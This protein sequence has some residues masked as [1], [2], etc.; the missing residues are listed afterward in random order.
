MLCDVTNR[1][2]VEREL[3]RIKPDV[4][5]HLAAMTSVDW[6][7]Q[8]YEQAC[9]V[10]VYG[11]NIVCEVA[12]NT[13]GE[14]KVA[15]IS[16]DMV[17]DGKDG[18]YDEDAPPNPINAYGMTKFGAE[19]IAQLYNAKIIRISRC[20]HS[21]SPDILEYLEKVKNGK[22]VHVPSFF[23]RSYCHLDF[24][25]NSFFE[26]A[27]RFD[28]MPE[29]LHIA[30][31]DNISFWALVHRIARF[32]YLDT[33]LVKSRS[34]EIDGCVPRPYK[35]GLDTSLAEL[36]GIPVYNVGQSIVRISNENS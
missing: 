13:I 11:T 2:E 7:E 34:E 12:E 27:K 16:S 23:I 4:V 26:Y 30:G 17:F 33:S 21:K 10:N 3:R 35:T 15:L 14:G 24:M 8:N 6:C 31:R 36:I 19:G 20:F 9:A 18:F 28:E 29:I 5:L 22:E 32:T 25:A 1:A